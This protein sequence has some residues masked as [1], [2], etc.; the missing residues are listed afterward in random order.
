VNFFIFNEIF[1]TKQFHEIFTKLLGNA[2]VDINC[3][4]FY[5]IAE[6]QFQALQLVTTLLAC[7]HQSADFCIGHRSIFIKKDRE[8]EKK[9]Y[10]NL[11]T[12]T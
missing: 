8:K 11:E 12:K 10:K 3:L 4:S 2:L 6:E 5:G 9:E 7:T 1:Q